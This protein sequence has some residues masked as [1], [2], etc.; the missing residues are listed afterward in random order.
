[1]RMSFCHLGMIC[2]SVSLK[3][4]HH[5]PLTVSVEKGSI[6]FRYLHI[7]NYY[8]QF[9][10][11]AKANDIASVIQCILRQRY[12]T[13]S[14]VIVQQCFYLTQSNLVRGLRTKLS[15]RINY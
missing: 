5:N 9:Q 13:G 11:S 7:Q 1:M 3:I 12:Q 4:C 6:H 10:K 15:G 2:L 8:I 14:E